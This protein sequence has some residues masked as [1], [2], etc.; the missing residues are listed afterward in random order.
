[1]NSLRVFVA[2]EIPEEIKQVIARQT[3]E[4]RAAVGRSVRWV[5]AENNHL[6]LKFIGAFKPAHLDVFERAVRDVCDRQAPFNITVDG[7]GCFPNIR[8]PRVIWIGMKQPAPVLEQFQANLEA[9]STPLG[10][11]AEARSF[12]AHLTIGR[13]RGQITLEELRILQAQ[14]HT[15]KLGEAGMFVV[16]SVTLFKSDLQPSGPR[17]TPLFTAQLGTQS[18]G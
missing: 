5:V 1:M 14:L 17:Y 3:V 18:S 13:V 15:F 4:M 8:S 7:L 10:Y 12:S 6:T 11:P 2:I 16:R 9:V